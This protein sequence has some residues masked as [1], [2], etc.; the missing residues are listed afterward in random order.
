M[1]FKLELIKKNH[2]ENRRGYIHVDNLN[3][4]RNSAK[5]LSDH[6]ENIEDIFLKTKKW[7][8]EPKI[9]IGLAEIDR[10]FTSIYEI[11]Y[12]CPPTN[13]L[14]PLVGGQW[15]KEMPALAKQDEVKP[16]NK[17]NFLK[18]N[19]ELK[20]KY[21]RHPFIQRSDLGDINDIIRLLNIHRKIGWT[22]SD[23]NF[24][25]KPWRTNNFHTNDMYLQWLFYLRTGISIY[26]YRFEYM[27]PLLPEFIPFGFFYE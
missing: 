8:E 27:P 19:K 5:R 6:R 23:T 1:N 12:L 17:T 4:Y 13:D 3:F 22:L 16:F 2:R 20:Q 21:S 18:I 14:S 15:V 26:Q 11:Q 7:K 9:L 25:E 10:Y 24:Y